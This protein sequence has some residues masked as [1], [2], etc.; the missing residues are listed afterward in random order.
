M[1]GISGPWCWIKTASENGCNDGDFQHLSLTLML[2][3]YYGPLVGILIFGLVCMLSIIILLQRSSTHLHGGNRQR[4]RSSMKDIGLVLIYPVV[5]C[6]FCFFLLVNRIYSATHTNSNDKPN[7][8]PLWIIHAVA[9]PGRILI[10]ALAFLLHPH[11]WKNVLACRGR[12]NNAES[13]CISAEYS[14]PPEADD[15]HHGYTIRPS[16]GG[17]G[18]PSNGLLFPTASGN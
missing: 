18:S 4:Y 8:Y 6:L 3:M 15:I 11:V 17:Y 12:S 9:D 14:V 5:Y 7:N 1:Y 10:P 16:N 13:R 2:V